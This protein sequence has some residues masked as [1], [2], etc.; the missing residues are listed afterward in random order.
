[1]SSTSILY[2]NVI[3]IHLILE[4]QK[5]PSCT[6]MSQKPIFAPKGRFEFLLERSDWGICDE[7][8]QTGNR[9]GVPW[10]KKEGSLPLC[11]LPILLD[12]LLPGLV[13]LL[14]PALGAEALPGRI[15]IV[16][17]ALL[18][19]QLRLIHVDPAALRFQVHL[20]PAARGQGLKA[21]RRQQPD[22]NRLFW[23]FAFPKESPAWII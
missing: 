4:C 15:A 21:G 16:T 22:G 1:M 11:Q 19:Q 20:P 14:P 18:A 13:V 3:N 9:N 10:R 2:Q 5:Y 8:E 17:T 7:P 6:R 12:L 23:G